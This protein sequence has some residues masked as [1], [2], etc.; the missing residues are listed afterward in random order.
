V[1]GKGEIGN[2]CRKRKRIFRIS[3]FP[4]FVNVEAWRGCGWAV[5][6]PVMEGAEGHV[7]TNV[8]MVAD[9]VFCWLPNNGDWQWRPAATSFIAQHAMFENRVSSRGT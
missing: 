1:Q 9:E 4:C 2:A 8:E 5:C 7:T 3:P 6:A